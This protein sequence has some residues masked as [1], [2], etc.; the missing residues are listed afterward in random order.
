MINPLSRNKRSRTND[1]TPADGSDFEIAIS[2]PDSAG[3]I[4]NYSF[5]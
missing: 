2:S 5:P 3:Y 4:G 1:L